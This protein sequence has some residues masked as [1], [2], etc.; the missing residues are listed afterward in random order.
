MLEQKYIE[1][2]RRL[3]MVDDS[4]KVS[5]DPGVLAENFWGNP[6]QISGTDYQGAIIL[7]PF[8]IPGARS[9]VVFNESGFPLNPQSSIYAATGQMYQ[10]SDGS[11]FR[12]ENWENVLPAIPPELQSTHSLDG[13]N[14]RLIGPLTMDQLG[15]LV[16]CTFA[17]KGT[18][19]ADLLISLARDK[20]DGATDAH[21]A[22][23]TSPLAARSTQTTKIGSPRDPC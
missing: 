14:N 4:A 5:F 16:V 1:Q 23:P 18:M 15:E 7:N 3:V 20:D 21:L 9:L 17:I 13:E 8:K 10:S 2:K 19:H 12:F 11:K 6:F 22:N